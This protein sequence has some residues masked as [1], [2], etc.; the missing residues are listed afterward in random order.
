VEQP[1]LELDAGLIARPAT[2]ADL[3][4]AVQFFNECD[5]RY[6][7]APPHT[8]TDLRWLWTHP[9]F[10]LSRDARLVH[11]GTGRIVCYQQVWAPAPGIEH[12]AWGRVH[13]AREG[14]G[15]GTA[16]LEW[17][18][19]RAAARLA[20][21][22]DGTRVTMHAWCLG[23]QEPSRRL[24]RDRGFEL[25]RHSLHLR[26]DLDEREPRTSRWPEGLRL[27]AFDPHRLRDLYDAW[28]EAFRDHWGVVPLE[29]E[30]G[31]AR[32]RHWIET[33]G[34]D[35]D[36]WFVV[37]AGDEIAGFCLCRDRSDEDPDMA[38]VDDLGVRRA[39]RGRG[40]ATALLA[41]AF[42]TAR[43]RGRRRVGLG[44]DAESL[45]GALRLY[46]K[47]GMRTYRRFESYDK[48]LRAGHDLATR[49]IGD[50]SE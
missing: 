23:E 12:R 9:D 2:I 34:H 27:E 5:R 31:L 30:V 3:A 4:A 37:R 16:M 32:F 41:H 44:V 33:A 17:A 1:E 18:E 48:E 42:A 22:P 8:E 50:N 20:E 28:A 45:T 26:I 21:A 46:E 29:P 14:R 39:W 43:R 6:P 24:L 10:A 11:D 36:L 49:E 19:R 13:P 40:L 15:L 7:E 35:P 38:W 25:T 47:V